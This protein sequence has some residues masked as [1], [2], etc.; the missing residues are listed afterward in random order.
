ML[1]RFW[2]PLEVLVKPIIALFLEATFEFPQKSLY[3]E[4][5]RIDRFLR[6]T[7]NLYQ[8]VSNCDTVRSNRWK[9]SVE[10]YLISVK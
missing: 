10:Q 3:K 9:G 7:K 6:R 2:L 8:L 5:T 1:I 4:N